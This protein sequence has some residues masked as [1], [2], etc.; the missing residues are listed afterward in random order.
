MTDELILLFSS[1]C[2]FSISL[3]GGGVL[4]L[5][6]FRKFALRPAS[7]HAARGRTV[8]WSVMPSEYPFQK[9]GHSFCLSTSIP[10]SLSLSSFFSFV[11]CLFQHL[12][13]AICVQMNHCISEFL[14]ALLTGIGV[15]QNPEMIS[16]QFQSLVS[17]WNSKHPVLKVSLRKSSSLRSPKYFEWA[18]WP[19]I[20]K[21]WGKFYIWNYISKTQRILQNLSI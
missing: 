6:L 20:L 1:F 7:S 5:Q 9:Y 17:G 13:Y 3:L 14:T 11:L 21:N 19:Q 18:L 12:P 2:L 10:M 4:E 16:K 15:V 8:W